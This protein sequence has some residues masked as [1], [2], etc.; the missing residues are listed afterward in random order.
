MHDENEEWN[1]IVR[2]IRKAARIL[3]RDLTE[4]DMPDYGN[5][6]AARTIHNY[7]WDQVKLQNIKE[8]EK[9]GKS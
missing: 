1:T 9:N 7:L 5:W 2:S 6:F 4:T 8:K 3:K